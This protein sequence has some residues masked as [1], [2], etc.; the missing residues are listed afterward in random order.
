[1]LKNDNQNKV[2]QRPFWIRAN[3][4]KHVWPTFNL[5]LRSV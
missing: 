3:E 4:F 1:M 5:Y 2:K